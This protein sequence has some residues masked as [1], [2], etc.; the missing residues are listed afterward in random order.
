MPSGALAAAVVG[1]DVRGG[2]RRVVEGPGGGTMAKRSYEQMV[3]KLARTLRVPA[4]EVRTLSEVQVA[5]IWR[6]FEDRRQNRISREDAANRLLEIGFFDLPTL[7]QE[8]D[9][10]VLEQAVDEI[11]AVVDYH[12]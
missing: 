10:G 2:K 6:V 9:R 4:E 7:R 11:N 12:N 3:D 8:L 5:T 1:S